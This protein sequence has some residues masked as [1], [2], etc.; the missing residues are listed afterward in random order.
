MHSAGK[1][2]P[3]AWNKILQ[4]IKK[5]AVLCVAILAATITS[6]IVPPDKAYLDYFDWKTLTCLFCVLAVVCALKNISFF[7]VLQ[8]TTNRDTLV[9][10]PVLPAQ[11]PMNISNTRMVLLKLGQRSKSTVAKPVEDMIEDTWNAAY[12]SASEKE[13]YMPAMSHVTSMMASKTINRNARI[14]SIFNAVL[15]CPKRAR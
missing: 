11:A 5:N 12:V 9:P 8:R 2:T 4:W 13:E 7:T 1:Q 6:F 3:V 10:P 14:S 15:I